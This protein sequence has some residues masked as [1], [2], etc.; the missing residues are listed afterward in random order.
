MTQA[1]INAK[2]Q[3]YLSPMAEAAVA[4][5][6]DRWK[7][8]RDLAIAVLEEIWPDTAIYQLEDDEHG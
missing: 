8:D 6:V 1:L 5:L 4:N 7:F 2:T 3:C